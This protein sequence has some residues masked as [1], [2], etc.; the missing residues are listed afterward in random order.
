MVMKVK[1]TRL[2][3]FSH[4]L[5]RVSLS[6]IGVW[7]INAKIFSKYM[8]PITASITYRLLR[9]YTLEPKIK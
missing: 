8:Q 2:P 4:V 3:D 1:K 5:K 6:N 9:T 7:I